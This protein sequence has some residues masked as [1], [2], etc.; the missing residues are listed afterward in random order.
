MERQAY[1]GFYDR[2][3]RMAGGYYGHKM[4]G[5]WNRDPGCSGDEEVEVYLYNVKCDE[6]GALPY[7]KCDINVCEECR[8]YTRAAPPNIF[9]NR[10]PHINAFRRLENIMCLCPS[11]DTEMEKQLA[12]TFLNEVC[13]CDRY[14]RWI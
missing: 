2:N 12:G 14:R 5:K 8:Y 13:D 10:F 7:T 11:C 9:P 6:A 4:A 3:E 1:R